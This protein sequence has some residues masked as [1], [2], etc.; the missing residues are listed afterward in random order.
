ML[1]P[2]SKEDAK[3]LGWRAFSRLILSAAA[4]I[5]TGIGE[6]AVEALFGKDTEDDDETDEPTEP[7]K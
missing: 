7:S 1:A 4:A 6:Y 5:G 3:K 2:L